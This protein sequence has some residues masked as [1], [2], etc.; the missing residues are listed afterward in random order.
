VKLRSSSDF[1]IYFGVKRFGCGARCAG[2]S[3]AGTFVCSTKSGLAPK[4]IVLADVDDGFFDSSFRQR[5][6]SCWNEIRM[7]MNRIV[8]IFALMTLNSAWAGPRTSNGDYVVLLHGLGRTPLS[9]KRLEWVLKRENYRVINAAYPS[10]RVSIQDAADVWLGNILRE[11]TTDKTVKIHFVTHSLGGIVLR[12]Y[13]SDHRIEN[14]GR[15]VMM[16]PPNQ[17]SELAERLKGNWLYR[18]CTG[19][20]GQQ[21]GMGDSS[22]PRRLGAA[23]FE[24][25]IIAGDRSLNP[26]FS[27]W[28]PGADDGKVS[29]RSTELSGMQ[30]FLVVHHS[31]T[32][33]AWSTQVASAVRQFLRTGV[34]REGLCKPVPRKIRIKF[35][36]WF[37][38]VGQSGDEERKG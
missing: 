31:H 12:Q 37:S 2:F 38:T 6:L 29:V 25:G 24:V 30:D 18:F 7:L 14:L 21:V 1:A 15:V 16:A 17:G 27:A 20:G 5:A 33:M 3:G 9:M 23:D 10:T 32:W 4:G 28:I 19:P 8:I 34:L 36:S 11:R 22:L 13:L 35:F 26:L